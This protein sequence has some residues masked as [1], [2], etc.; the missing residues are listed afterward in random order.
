MRNGHLAQNG[1][2]GRPARAS[3]GKKQKV[4]EDGQTDRTIVLQKREEGET[5]R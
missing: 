4:I 2:P 5:E 1:P 3:G